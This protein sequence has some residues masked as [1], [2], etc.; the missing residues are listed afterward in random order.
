[1]T[2]AGGGDN[3]TAWVGFFG[4]AGGNNQQTHVVKHGGNLVVWDT[5]YET[6][7]FTKEAEPRYI[8]LTDYGNLT[9]FNGTIATMPGKDARRDLASVDLDGFTGH[10]TLIGAGFNTSNPQVRLGG[11][12]TG[13]RAL[14]LGTG[15]CVV[16]PYLDNQAQAAEVALLACRQNGKNLPAAG[17]PSPEFLRE[18]LMQARTVL[19]TRWQP[20]PAGATDLRLFRV[21]VSY[22]I[23]DALIFSAGKADEQ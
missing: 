15:F 16:D 6:S 20:A 2:V 9:F 14:F 13:M 10:F 4:S 12:G 5:W 23:G 3:T 11:T 1:M 7:V 18:M 22:R 21:S 19:P 8:H 17:K